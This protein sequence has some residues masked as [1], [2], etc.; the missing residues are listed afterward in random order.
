VTP[1]G[2]LRDVVPLFARAASGVLAARVVLA[3]HGVLAP[4]WPLLLPGVYLPPQR[5]GTGF[6]SAAPRFLGCQLPLPCA[7][8]ELCLSCRPMR[9]IMATYESNAGRMEPVR[10]MLLTWPPVCTGALHPHWSHLGG[11]SCQHGQ[12]ERN[13]VALCGY[14]HEGGTSQVARSRLDYVGDVLEVAPCWPTCPCTWS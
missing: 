6:A 11:W 10:M 7:S 14:A 8:H 4:R 9:M 12:R 1:A 5:V 13:Q 3:P 2:C